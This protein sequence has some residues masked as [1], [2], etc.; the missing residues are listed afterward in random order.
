MMITLAG[1]NKLLCKLE[2]D[3]QFLLSQEKATATYIVSEGTEPI[4]P[5]IITKR[6]SHCWKLKKRFVQ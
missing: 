2:D 5:D 6:R 3:K 1:A 4:V